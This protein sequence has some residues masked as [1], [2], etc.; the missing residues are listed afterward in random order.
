MNHESFLHCHSLYVCASCGKMSSIMPT[1]SHLEIKNHECGQINGQL[2]FGKLLFLGTVNLQTHQF[3]CTH[4]L[5]EA[6]G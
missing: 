6:S 5:K 2:V 1:T 3:H 4:D